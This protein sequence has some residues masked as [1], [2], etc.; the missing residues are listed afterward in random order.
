MVYTIRRNRFFA[1]AAAAVIIGIFMI[2]SGF[3]SNQDNAASRYKYFTSIRIEEGD[4]LWSIA[5]E[6]VSEEYD[7]VEE[8]ISELKS[9]N[10]LTGDTIHYGQNLIVAYYSDEIK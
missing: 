4:S 2:L 1:A 10:N 3:M 5:S 8:Y 6:Y 7:G 9:M